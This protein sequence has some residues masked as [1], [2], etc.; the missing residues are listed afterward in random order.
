[1]KLVVQ[2]ESIEAPRRTR[3]RPKLEDVA[4]IESRLLEVALQEFLAEGY[5]GTSLSRI[6]KAAG[7]SKTTLY[8]RFSSKEELFRA[9]LQRQIDNLAAVAALRSPKGK[10]DLVGGLRAYGNRTLEIS[11]EG[12]LLQVNR[13]IYSESARFPELGLAAA[14][15]SQSGIDDVS[16]FIRTCADADGIP[17]RDPQ[18]IAEAFIFML[19][20]WY[21][22]MLLTNRQVSVRQ[23][24]RWVDTA[25]QALVAGRAEW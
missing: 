10:L 6:V 20:G 8:T 21:V 2:N 17:C 12:D 16:I 22:D 1:M 25:V 19:R 18:A 23:R 9:A 3:G 7:I 4:Q 14:E 24:Q 5:G 11:L 13:L 15:R